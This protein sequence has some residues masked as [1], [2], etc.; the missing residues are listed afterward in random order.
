MLVR[1]SPWVIIKD[2]VNT[3]RRFDSER[4]DWPQLILFFILPVIVGF[5][6]ACWKSDIAV[7]I[8]SALINVSAIFIALL[9]NL[10]VL[11]TSSIDRCMDQRDKLKSHPHFNLMT[12][13]G[14]FNKD[15]LAVMAYLLECTFFN[16]SF[17]IL[18]AVILIVVSFMANIE[19][20]YEWILSVTS[21][22]IVCLS[23][24]FVMTLLM[25]LQRVHRYTAV[26]TTV[27]NTWVMRKRDELDRKLKMGE[28]GEGRVPKEEIE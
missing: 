24:V 11:V 15:I 6:T 23:M 18:T 17:A 14:M 16:V 1:L 26:N 12:K 22:A 7:S 13:E 25:I 27:S 8:N 21:G 19:A 20:P 28:H 9:L 4:F 3:F 10:Q 5:L 2:H